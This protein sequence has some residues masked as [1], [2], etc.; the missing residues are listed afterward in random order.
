MTGVMEA[1][2]KRK[3]SHIAFMLDT[4]G[5][6]IRTGNNENGKPVE[7]KA[8]DLLELSKDSSYSSHR[9]RSPRKLQAYSLLLR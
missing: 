8:G 5:P 9:L 6:E 4:K 3:N 2:T 7:V 1:M